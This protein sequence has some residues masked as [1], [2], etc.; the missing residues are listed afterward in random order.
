[1]VWGFALLRFETLRFQYFHH[2]ETPV[3]PT[4][5][6]FE[7]SSVHAHTKEK[8]HKMWLY[9]LLLR[10]LDS[11][12]RLQ[13]MSLM[14]YHYST[15]RCQGIV[16]KA[17]EK[18]RKEKGSPSE[19]LNQISSCEKKLFGFIRMGSCHPGI[20]QLCAFLLFLQV[21]RIFLSLFFSTTN[22]TVGRRN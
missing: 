19:P 22:L 20:N 11:N 8:N 10:G 15:P 6:P 4:P 13:V 7:S 5:F 12:E 9:S 3:S 2:G 16:S 14:R 17:L 1:M 18:S 21:A